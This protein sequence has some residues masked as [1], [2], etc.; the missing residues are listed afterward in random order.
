M[1]ILIYLVY[2]LLDG[3]AGYVL[4]KFDNL[5]YIKIEK[6]DHFGLIDLVYDKRMLEEEKEEQGM[7]PQK[8]NMHRQFTVMALMNCEVLML[9]V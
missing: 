3:V 4:P 8:S 1:P 7:K 9:S 2:F 6:G 5:V